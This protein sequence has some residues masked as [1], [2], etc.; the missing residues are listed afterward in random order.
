MCPDQH[1]SRSIDGKDSDPVSWQSGIFRVVDRP[2][3]A[4]EHR[5]TPICPDPSP[6]RSIDGKRTDPVNWQ[7]G[8]PCVVDRPVCTIKNRKTTTHCP[9]PSPSRSIDGKRTDPVIWQRGI[10]CVVDRPVCAIK[11][12]KTTTACPDPHP[13]RSIDGKRI[14]YVRWQAGILGTI[15]CDY[16]CGLIHLCQTIGH[17]CPYH[18]TSIS[19]G[20]DVL[21]RRPCIPPY[22]LGYGQNGNTDEYQRT[23]QVLHHILLSCLLQK[24]YVMFAKTLMWL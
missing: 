11:N 15:V 24:I 19:H 10:P 7:R 1:T 21:P 5:K 12:R 17:T 2:V 22:L 8:I 18:T 6:S 9:D 13:S 16:T 3:C 20:S 14:D 23:Y 4:I